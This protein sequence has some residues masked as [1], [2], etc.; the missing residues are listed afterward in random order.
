M[1]LHNNY[2]IFCLQRVLRPVSV[3]APDCVRISEALL[4]SYGFTEAATLSWS[5]AQSLDCLKYQVNAFCIG[6]F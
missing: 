5:L 2:V 3:I 1:E 6:D 4:L